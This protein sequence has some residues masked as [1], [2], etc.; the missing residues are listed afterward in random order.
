MLRRTPRRASKRV[1]A[2]AV[3]KGGARGEAG[4][5]GGEGEGEGEELRMRHHLHEAE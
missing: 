5:G 1:R 4:E 3:T 2:Q